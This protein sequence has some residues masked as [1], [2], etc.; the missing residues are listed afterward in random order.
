M[1]RYDIINKYTDKYPKAKKI[2]VRNFVGTAP[3]DKEANQYNLNMDAMLYRWNSDTILAIK[4]ALV[5]L[6]IY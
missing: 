3:N 1:S 2:A 5:E 4:E 6:G